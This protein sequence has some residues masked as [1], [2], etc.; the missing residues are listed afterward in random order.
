LEGAWAKVW[1]KQWQEIIIN[2][3]SKEYLIIIYTYKLRLRRAIKCLKR[4]GKV[5]QSGKIGWSSFGR[6]ETKLVEEDDCS[7]LS[8]DDD[9]DDNDTD[10][11]DDDQE[12][13]EE[14]QKIISKHMKLQE[15]HVNLLCCHEKLIDSIGYVN[16]GKIFSISLAHMHHT[17]LIYLVLTLVA[18]KY[19]HCVMSMLL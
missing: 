8:S 14:F 9:D 19:S 10:N 3:C 16:N 13:L 7:T 15:K 11:E 6:T 12:R 18:L 5:Y 2:K 1:V 17:L 4:K